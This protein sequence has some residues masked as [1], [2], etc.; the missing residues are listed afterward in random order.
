MAAPNRGEIWYADLD[1]IK[2]HEQAGKRPVLILS[3]NS[4]NHGPATLVIVAPLTRTERRLPI[5]VEVNPPEGGIK[6]RSFIM[7]EAVRSITKDRLLAGPWGTVSHQTVTKVVDIIAI[8][9]EV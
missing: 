4:F 7:C 8:L 5:H 1:P 3:A 6:Q 2:G 9:L